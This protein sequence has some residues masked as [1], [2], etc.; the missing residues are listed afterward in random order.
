M[1]DIGIEVV[2]EECIVDRQEGKEDV[3]KRMI[4]MEEYEVK[5]YKEDKM[6]KEMEE[7]KE[8]KKGRRNI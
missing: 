5:E 6:K 2:E 3:G 7:I 1:K 4:Q 8:V